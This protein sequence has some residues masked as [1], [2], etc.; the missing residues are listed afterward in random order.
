VEH[1]S[2]DMRR[3][4][5]YGAHQQLRHRLDEIASCPMSCN[6]R[7]LC[8]TLTSELHSQSPHSEELQ[9]PIKPC[10]ESGPIKSG[11]LHTLGFPVVPLEKQRNASFDFPSPGASLRS[12]NE[13]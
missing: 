1:M 2:R 7:S 6:P 12:L 3:K 4:A 11:V 10:Y 13:R 5:F 8:D 9:Q